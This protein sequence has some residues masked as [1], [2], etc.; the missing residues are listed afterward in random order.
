MRVDTETIS[1]SEFKATCLARL[2]RVRRTGR[3][4]LVTKRGTPIAEVVPA[5]V[6]RRADGWLGSASGTGRITGDLVP[7]VVSADEWEAAR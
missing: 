4:L 2:E 5:T 6:E 1:I 3:R 7:P